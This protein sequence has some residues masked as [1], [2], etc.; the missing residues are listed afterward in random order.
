MRKPKASSQVC[1]N[2]LKRYIIDGNNLIGKI[3]QL[4]AIPKVNRQSARERLCHILDR[5]FSSKKIKVSLHF[6]GFAGPAIKASFLS[7]HYSSGRPADDL[8]KQEIELSRNPKL[9]TI[10]SSDNNLTS[11]AKA[12]SCTIIKADTF[13]KGL[14][15]KMDN[16]EEDR[17]K[18][19][20][21]DE[22]KKL[23][24]T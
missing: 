15:K 22:I 8:I 21:N 19:I 16:N 7:I 11:F 1:V 18:S 6:D 13:A 2:M 23:F 9:L 3:P 24:E 4:K 14:F 10:V 12:C 17:I 5:Y 20:S